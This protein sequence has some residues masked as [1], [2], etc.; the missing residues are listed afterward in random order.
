MALVQINNRV[1]RL[2]LGQGGDYYRRKKSNTQPFGTGFDFFKKNQKRIEAL[3]M[4]YLFVYNYSY[5]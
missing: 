3:M 5:M 4:M 1:H 2:A